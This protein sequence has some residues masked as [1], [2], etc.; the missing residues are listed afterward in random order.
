MGLQ[1]GC[2][3]IYVYHQTGQVVTLSVHQT[4][5]VVVLAVGKAQRTAQIKSHLEASEPE[6]GVYL[7]LF[8]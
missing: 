1:D 4:V 3:A 6:V 5:Y 2:M 8:E 7:L